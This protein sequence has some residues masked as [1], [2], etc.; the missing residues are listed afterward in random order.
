ME[1]GYGNK[2]LQGF[3]VRRVLGAVP[4]PQTLTCECYLL[5]LVCILCAPQGTLT[6]EKM[7]S[8]S[9]ERN[10]MGV[11]GGERK[12][13]WPGR[14][15]DLA[16][17]LCISVPVSTLTCLMST[18]PGS[19]KP[20]FPHTGAHRA[21]CSHPDPRLLTNQVSVGEEHDLSVPRFPPFQMG[22]INPT[23]T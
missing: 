1:A 3:S 16:P 21:G 20:T 9:Y 5:L 22:R 15:P 7:G 19:P 18:E 13:R 12:M 6:K 14:G 23:V 17:R 11:G 10:M 4:G 8:R 2:P